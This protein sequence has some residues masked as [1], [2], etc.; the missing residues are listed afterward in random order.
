MSDIVLRMQAC[1]WLKTFHWKAP[2]YPYMA[3]E[4]LQR[5]LQGCTELRSDHYDIKCMFFTRVQSAD[6][7]LP[8]PVQ[9]STAQ[10]SVEFDNIY[11]TP[12]RRLGPCRS[13]NKV[14]CLVTDL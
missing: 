1:Q 10:R 5:L 11:S 13:H 9:P 12:A 8:S 7:W 6:E 3:A 14:L 4:K 2:S